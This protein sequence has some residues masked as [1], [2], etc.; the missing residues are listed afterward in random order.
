MIDTRPSASHSQFQN[1]P[2]V[3]TQLAALPRCGGDTAV[4]SVERNRATERDR[5]ATGQAFTPQ[6]RGEAAQGG[7]ASADAGGKGKVPVAKETAAAKPAPQGKKAAPDNCC[8]GE[9]TSVDIGLNLE[10]A[11]N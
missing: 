6:P 9:C 4:A 7:G 2:G 11:G 1:S 5:N 3:G 8:Q 10:P